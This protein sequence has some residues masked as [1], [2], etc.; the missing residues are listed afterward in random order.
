MNK[1]WIKQEEL[2][3]VD[4]AT[5]ILEVFHGQLR[6]EDEEDNDY[7]KERI[8]DAIGVISGE[9]KASRHPIEREH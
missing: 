3:I 5:S 1:D 9:Q 7:L 8:G 2:L 4:L 6:W